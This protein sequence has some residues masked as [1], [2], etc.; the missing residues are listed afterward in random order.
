[1]RRGL[2][3]KISKI[4]VFGAGIM[5]VGIAQVAATAGFEVTIRDIKDAFVEKGL[6]VLKNSFKELWTREK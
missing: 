4:T 5:G 3:V 1:M 2:P 6:T